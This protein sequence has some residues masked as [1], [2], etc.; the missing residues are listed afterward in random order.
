MAS[1]LLAPGLFHRWLADA[2]ADIVSAPIG[3]HP[4][5][6]ELIAWRYLAARWST[7]AA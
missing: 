2:G 3:A 6:V 7:E 5:L 1:W 4:L